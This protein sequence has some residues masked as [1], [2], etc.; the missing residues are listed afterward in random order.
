MTPDKR[1]TMKSLAPFLRA[2]ASQFSSLVNITISALQV[3]RRAQLVAVVL[4]AFVIAIVLTSAVG[5]ARSHRQQWAS[6]RTVLVAVRPITTGEEF[7]I[8]NTKQID[9]PLA[10]LP[11]DAISK[12]QLGDTARIDLQPQTA[13]TAAMVVPANDSVQIPDGW[14]VVALPNDMPTPP[15]H[16]RDA[17]DVVAGESVIAAGVVVA[18]LSPLTIAVPAEVAPAVASVVH[19]GEASLVATR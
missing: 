19:M 1:E 7:T 6:H 5:S 4:F 11:A 10:V 15:L 12:M 9:L 13:I 8:E 2:V 17:V 3:K 14:R 18:S 16:L